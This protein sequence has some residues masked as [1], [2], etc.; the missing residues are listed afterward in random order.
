MAVIRKITAGRPER[1]A[2]IIQKLSIVGCGRQNGRAQSP[3]PTPNQ[4]VLQH[5][6]RAVVV[7]VEPVLAGARGE[8]QV[9]DDVVEEPALHRN[10][11]DAERRQPRA[12]PRSTSGRAGRR[13]PGPR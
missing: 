3:S 1:I 2:V 9:L 7:D 12:R 10:E 5:L 13:G 8:D 11:Q 6:Q 4:G